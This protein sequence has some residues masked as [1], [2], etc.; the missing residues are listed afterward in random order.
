VFEFGRRAREKSDI[1]KV[2]M[3]REVGGAILGK[4]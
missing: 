3:V 1:V 4:P 2:D